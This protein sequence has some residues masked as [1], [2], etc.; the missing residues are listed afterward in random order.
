MNRKW[1][2]RSVEE[3]ISRF[4]RCA[5]SKEEW[6][7]EAHLVA[8][9]W[10]VHSL[11]S[12]RALEAMRVRIRGHNESVGTPNTDDSGYHETIT[13]LYISGIEER[14]GNLANRDLEASLSM[15]LTSELAESTWPLRFYSRQRLFSVHARR[16]WVEPDQ[17][18]GESR[19][20]QQ[21]HAALREP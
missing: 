15:L 19:V 16:T 7:H 21:S 6:T 4:E 18:H 13:R 1:T 11:G 3:F 14:L 5:V 17:L 10:Y 8:G 2:Y 20:A 9:F 12:A